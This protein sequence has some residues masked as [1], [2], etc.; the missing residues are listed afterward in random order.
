MSGRVELWWAHAGDAEQRRALV[1]E[2]L[3]LHL[4]CRPDAVVLRRT[5]SG[6]PELDWPRSGLRFSVASSGPAAL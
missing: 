3:A 4:D 5:D 6:R 2:P 1:R